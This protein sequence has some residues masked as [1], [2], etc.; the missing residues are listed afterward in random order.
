MTSDKLSKFLAENSQSVPAPP[1]NEWDRI[2]GQISESRIGHSRLTG[3][4]PIWVVGSVI[5]LSLLLS[6]TYIGSG[7][8]PKGGVASVQNLAATPKIFGSSTDQ[9]VLDFLKETSNVSNLDD[10]DEFFL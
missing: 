10:E 6:L 5:T 3:V 2:Q 8:F 4:R 7:V 1:L 9:E